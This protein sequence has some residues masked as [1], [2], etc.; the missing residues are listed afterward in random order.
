MLNDGRVT[1]D[2]ERWYV[3]ALGK[4]VARFI[5]RIWMGDINVKTAP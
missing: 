4:V 5:G 2:F 3:L 1:E